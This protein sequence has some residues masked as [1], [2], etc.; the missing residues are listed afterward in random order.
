M[1]PPA[2]DRKFPGHYIDL[3]A[4]DQITSRLLPDINADIGPA[5]IIEVVGPIEY[6]DGLFIAVPLQNDQA[7][8]RYG[9]R[10][11]TKLRAQCQG[12]EKC[13]QSAITVGLVIPLC[14][15]IEKPFPAVFQ[16]GDIGWTRG[17]EYYDM[18]FYNESMAELKK[19]LA[20]LKKLVQKRPIKM[21]LPP[22]RTRN[23]FYESL[24]NNMLD[25]LAYCQMIFDAQ[26]KPVDFIYIEV[27]NNFESLTGLKNVIGKQV[28]EVIP[29]VSTSNPELLEI[30]GRVS[31]TG[32]PETFETY[33]EP[34]LRWFLV[35]VYSPRKKFFVAVFHNITDQKR[36]EKDLKDALRAARNVLEDFNVEKAKVGL[37]RVKEEAI[38]LSVGDGIFATDEGGH[39]TLMNKT[40]EKLL[41]QKS[42]EVVGKNFFDVI[43]IENE[44][45]ETVP[46]EKRPESMALTSGTTTTTTAHTTAEPAYYYV[47]QDKTKFPVA[48]TVTPVILD[49]KIIGAMT[50]IRDITHEKEIDKAKSEFVSLASHQLKT[51]PTAIK[52]LTERMLSGKTGEL[53]EKQ[54]EYLNDIRSENQRSIELVSAL[55]DVSRIEMGAFIVQSGEKNICTVV[56]G[57]LYELQSAFDKKRLKLEE[58]YPEGNTVVSIDEPLFRM[59]ISNLVMNAMNYTD[60]G[61]TI[62]VECRKVDKKEALGEKFLEDSSFVVIISDTGCGIP[63]Q[64]QDRLFTKFF[65]ADNARE[66][67]SD[68]T[69][70][71]LYIVKSILDNSG[72]SIWFTSE[73]NKGSTFYVAIPMTGMKAKEHAMI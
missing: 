15:E 5:M 58:V 60:D 40:A 49:G 7:A 52:L 26:G 43:L 72:G 56:H 30:Y 23:T 16:C 68:G 1:H 33:V 28:T 19:E 63:K 47:R 45:G 21:K 61:G 24:F 6:P 11:R 25:G 73:V 71:G 39:I 69:G 54:K 4:V 22:L 66:K 14:D 70:L 55:L 65:R 17:I 41:G 38:L 10:D 62:R 48:M 59:V 53:T 50:V 12:Q 32:N 31:L 57:V 42:K 35:S 51:P 64:Q 3:I 9:E 67:H 29:G 27:S 34:L 36:A 18:I 20:N 8:L 44:K 46:L 13:F 2:F 37:A